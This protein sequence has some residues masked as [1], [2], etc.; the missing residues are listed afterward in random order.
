VD[1]CIGRL[2]DAVGRQGGTMLITADHGNAELMQGPDGQAW[3]AHTT[4]PVPAILIEGER[5]KL[6]GH[7]NAITLRDN[8]GLAD[9][10]PT[11]LQILD[12]PQPA[13]MTGQSL[14]APMS[15]M[16]PTPKTARLPLS[17]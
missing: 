13:A 16:D 3:T 15:N 2:L 9:I 17:V 12:L 5:R 6:P 14:I 8:G 10:A 11:L 4:N 1:G 7:G